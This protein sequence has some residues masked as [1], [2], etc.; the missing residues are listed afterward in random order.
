M[1]FFSFPLTTCNIEPDWDIEPEDYMISCAYRLYFVVE[2]EC[3]M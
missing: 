1:W 2:V 3:T